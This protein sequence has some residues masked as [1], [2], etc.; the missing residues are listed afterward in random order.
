MNQI[1]DET[2][3][4]YADGELSPAERRAVTR[5]LARDPALAVR[6][7][8]FTSTGRNLAVSFRGALSGSQHL[9]EAIW[10]FDVNSSLPAPA[11]G[12]NV[13]ASLGSMSMAQLADWLRVPT[14]PLAA[15]PAL[16]LGLIC[17]AAGVWLALG[18]EPRGSDELAA[19]HGAGMV[20]P[21]SLQLALEKNLSGIPTEL[22]SATPTNAFASR[23]GEMCRQYVLAY[24]PDRR[25][26]GVACRQQ[27]GH[28]NVRAQ[29]ALK[30]PPAASEGGMRP[31]GD[32]SADRAPAVEAAVDALIKGVPLL[33]EEEAEQVRK[34]WRGAR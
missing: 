29:A 12:R 2:L 31:A 4:A 26:A 34:G 9:A 5:A 8:Q 25:Y 22:A 33:R 32:R 24:G 18:P 1:S 13:W 10:N 30:P 14:W 3:M 11:R 15:A 20:A 19:L 7:E 6:L 17:G 16:S 28:W 23:S 27:D 21:A